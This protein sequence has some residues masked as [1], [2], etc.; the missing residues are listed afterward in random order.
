L[1]NNDSGKVA[2]ESLFSPPY[3]TLAILVIIRY[4][5]L[6]QIGIMGKSDE[7]FWLFAAYWPDDRV[8]PWRSPD[9]CAICGGSQW[10][11]RAYAPG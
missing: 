7:T 11:A 3:R 10:R 6:R 4:H 2:P 8:C 9:R 5:C 1:K